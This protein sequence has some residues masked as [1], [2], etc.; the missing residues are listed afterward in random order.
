MRSSGFLGDKKDL[1]I[2]SEMFSDGVVRLVESGVITNARKTLHAGKIVVGFVL[3]TR[4]LYEW[5]NDNP[6]CEFHRQEYVNDPI[7]D[8]PE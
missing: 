5:V 3:G 1:G 4:S 2:H 7:C 6:L 8:R